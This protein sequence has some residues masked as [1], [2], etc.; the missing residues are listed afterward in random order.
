MARRIA[1]LTTESLKAL[2]ATHAVVALVPVGS[3]EPH[4]PHLPLGT[5]TVISEAAI[6]RAAILLENQP[7]RPIAALLAPPIPYGVTCFAEGFAGAI[8]VPAEA[9]TAFARAVV[10]G[11]LATGFTHVC[12]VNN[13]LEPAHDAAVRAAVTGFPAG[14]ASIACPLSR[15]WGRTLSAEFKSGACHA[16]RYETSLVLA[17]APATVDTA[18]ASALPDLAVSLSDGIKAGKHS[19]KAMGLDHAYTG[20]PARATAAEGA[21]LL[22]LLGTMI[23]TEVTEGLAAIS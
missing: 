13:H 8:S 15:R 4:G 17:A 18:A 20:A 7:E 16:G 2:L 3:V 10:A 23:A 19:F 22:L 14:R 21:E 6:A 5:D 12:L 1:E 9:L 11:Y